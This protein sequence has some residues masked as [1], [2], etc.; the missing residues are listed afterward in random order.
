MPAM[1]KL[2]VAVL[3]PVVL[4]PGLLLAPVWRLGGLGAGED[5]ILHYFP[6]RGFF[7]DAL[8]AGHWPWLNPWTGLGRPFAADP[9]TAVWYPITWLFAGLPPESAY[10]LSLWMHYS[11]AL[12]GMY[13]LLR[14]STLDRRAALFGGIAF[15]FCGFLLA[16]RAHYTMQHAAAWTPWVL[17]RLQRFVSRPANPARD[18]HALRDLAC[19]ALAVALQCLAGHVQIAALTA[20]G[21]LVFLLAQAIP[22]AGAPEPAPILRVFGRWLVAWVCAAG[23]FAVQWLP[24]A[25]Y[26]RLCTRVDRTYWDFVENSWNP[27]GTVGWLLPMLFGQRTPNFFE[28]PYWG[29]SHQVEQFVYAGIVPLLLAVMGL[30]GWRGDAGRRPWVI[31]GIFGMLLAL[32][33]FGPLCP[34]L[35]WLPGSSLFRCP[36]RALLLVNLAV[37]ALAAFTLHDLG[38]RLSPDVV[39]RRAWLLQCTGRPIRTTLL[40]VG[41]PL[42]LVLAAAPLVGEPTRAALLAAVRPWSPAVWVPLVL[43]WTGLTML[44]FAGQRWRKPGWLW[45][46]ILHVTVDLGIIGWTID[47]PP[48]ARSIADLTRPREPAPWMDA[49]RAS[50]RRL[51]VVTG[52]QDQTPGEY[53]DPLDKAVAN[54]NMLRRIPALT[55][56]GPLQPRAYVQRFGFQPWGESWKPGELLADTRWMRLCN[57][58]WVLLCDAHWPAPA[59]GA[60][61]TTTPAGWRLYRCPGAQGAAVFE[62]AAQPG[63][64]RHVVDNPAR[65]RTLVSTWSPEPDDDA[66]QT[67]TDAWPR[68]VLSQLA[69]PGWSAQVNGQ[70]TQVETVDGLLL[71]VGV[72]PGQSAEVLW[73]YF[74]PGLLP[75]ATISIGTALVLLLATLHAELTTRGRPS[76]P[77]ARSESP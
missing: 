70:N 47:V 57:V 50:G 56:Y 36:A 76:S 61:W 13:R 53:F 16:H 49:V 24:T 59:G 25:A 33:T 35:Y 71:A 68:V 23:L 69:L 6:M 4:L 14:S 73:T 12:W 62:D 41:V 1:W 75:G 34:L 27:A 40:L 45:L 65:Q 17:W 5:D 11:L 19:A 46:L 58:A 63:A 29:P 66:Q 28:Q 48:G 60:L 2:R 8:E 7:H 42:L 67:P 31:L 22:P 54:T 64:L 20:A 15:A 18:R 38:P 3:V 74:P 10:P 30:R 52:R 77:A 21:T 43:V 9:Q 55:D 32:G 51:W 72:P 26:L 44:A 39:R 37:A